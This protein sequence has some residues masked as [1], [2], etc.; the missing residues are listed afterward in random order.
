MKAFAMQI[1]A[2]LHRK[3]NTTAWTLCFQFRHNYYGVWIQCGRKVVYACHACFRLAPEFGR[4]NV[5]FYKFE[6]IH[7]DKLTIWRNERARSVRKV[8][9]EDHRMCVC[10]W[11]GQ[12]VFRPNAHTIF[13]EFAKLTRWNRTN[14]NL[15]T[16]FILL[17][18]F[19]NT[20]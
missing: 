5:Q 6:S 16:I 11:I 9:E 2:P 8:A 14:V 7:S 19:R 17:H 4:W 1:F 10:V 12:I 15:N 13:C 3:I 18:L 20:N